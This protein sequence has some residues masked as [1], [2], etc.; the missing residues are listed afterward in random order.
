MLGRFCVP[1]VS[2]TSGRAGFG[3]TAVP[4][5]ARQISRSVRSEVER[6]RAAL[7]L[8]RQSRDGVVGTS[9][10]VLDGRMGEG[11]VL[12][13]NL[14]RGSCGEEDEEDGRREKQTAARHLAP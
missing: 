10:K 7:E 1:T 4:Q 14:P 6:N 3:A 11:Q 13:V 12:Q 9:L 5:H 8:R 2:S